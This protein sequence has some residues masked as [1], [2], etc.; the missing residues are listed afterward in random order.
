MPQINPRS[1]SS[2]ATDLFHGFEK[3]ALYIPTSRIVSE[4]SNFMGECLVH[5]RCS[6]WHREVQQM[7]AGWM[8][9]WMVGWLDG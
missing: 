3:A 8:D 5:G 6:A 1:N 4:D 2:S 9:R 7:C